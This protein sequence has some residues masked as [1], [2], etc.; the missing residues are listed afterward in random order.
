MILLS[1]RWELALTVR[2]EAFFSNNLTP[3]FFLITSA[4][5]LL[6]S[7]PELLS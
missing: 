2:A 7:I 3:N 1:P 4:R 6:R 5:P